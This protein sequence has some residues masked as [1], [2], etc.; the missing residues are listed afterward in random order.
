MT[1]NVLADDMLDWTELPE[2][3]AELGVAGPFAG[4]SQ[5]A[6]IVAGGANFPNGVPWD[7][8][9]K[10][11]YDDIYVLDRTEGEWRTGF[12]LPRPLAYGASVTTDGGLLCIGGCDGDRCYS[13]VFMLNWN[14]VSGDIDTKFLPSLPE[15][16]AFMS[17]ARIGDVVYVAGGQSTMSDAD[18][19]NTFWSLNLVDGAKWTKLSSWNGPS[20]I[21]P[22]LA[23]QHD[24]TSDKVYLFS[25]RDFGPDREVNL[26]RDVQRFDPGARTWTKLSDAPRCLMAGMGS[27]MGAHHIMLAGGD[28]GRYWDQGL[29]DDH[30]GFPNDMLFVYHTVTDTWVQKGQLPKNQVTSVLVEWNGAWVIPSGEI[31]PAVRS[32]KVWQATW[33]DAQQRFSCLDYMVL[34]VYLMALVVMGAYFSTREKT[35]DDFFL[36]G[37]R[38]PWWAAGL[39]IFGTQ[40]SAITFMAIP[41]KAYA[42]DWMGF[43]YNMGIVAVAPL[44]IFC[45]LPFYRRLN[46]TTAY[47]YLEQRFNVAVRLFGSA[48][49]VIFQFGRLGIVLLLPSLA[50]SVVTGTSVYTCILVMGILA[51]V[52]TVMGGIEAVIWTDVLQVVVLM[53]GALFAMILVSLEV[54]GGFAGMFTT[55]LADSKL[56]MVDWNLDFTTLTI[57]VILLAWAN[58]LVPYASDQS[59]IQR[60]MTTK[61]ETASRRAIWTNAILAI[62]AS[63]LFF[64]MGTALYVFYKEHPA[65]LNPT[66]AS[67][68]A[69]FPWYIMHELPAGLSG[70]LIAGIFAAAMSS[71]DSSMNSMST[72]I[73]TDFYRRFRKGLT[74]TH[75]LRVARGLTALFGVV[76]TVFALVMASTDIKSIWDQFIMILGLLGGGLGGLFVLGIFTRRANG[77]GAIVGLLASGVVQYAVKTHTALHSFMFAL[78]GMVSCVVIGYL[79]SFFFPRAAR[80]L[81]DLTLFTVKS[82]GNDA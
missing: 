3:P 81:D 38:I 24:G 51:T 2:L 20:R 67:A 27:A 21:L 29:R 11:W 47:E 12:S 7:G 61:D 62:P 74:E 9:E 73:V 36:A 68:D 79:V 43:L 30:P 26:L 59:V 23:A 55:A 60:Y 33:A 72:A 71:L 4:V 80:D 77:P 31:R 19:T 82:A 58:H 14:P 50:L 78:T 34:A 42:T 15:P 5:D 32:P 64:G 28:D 75:C 1:A 54:E 66:M 39:S 70:L 52:Y 40:L 53:G 8:G 13:D 22:V 63:L 48:L 37:G 46:V 16:L 25:G 65:D 18:A 76:G 57:W 6:L 10:V 44:I 17:A 41:A 45:F 56:H 49:F 35:T 69:I